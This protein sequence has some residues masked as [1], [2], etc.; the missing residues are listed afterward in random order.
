MKKQK[1]P[2]SLGIWKEQ[3]FK[4]ILSSQKIKYTFSMSMVAQP[5]KI[6]K[7]QN[8]KKFKFTQ[9]EG[10]FFKV[11]SRPIDWIFPSTEFFLVDVY[12]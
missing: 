6:F 1:S 7:V 4:N 9:I 8:K 5:F 12:K 10:K 2:K 11:Q 3:N